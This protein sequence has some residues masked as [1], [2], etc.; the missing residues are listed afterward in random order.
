ME[1]LLALGRGS[2]RIQRAE[3]ALANV[4]PQF[5]FTDAQRLDDRLGGQ[6]HRQEP[7]IQ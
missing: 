6:D 5:A 4:R 3:P 7:I 1:I 2:R